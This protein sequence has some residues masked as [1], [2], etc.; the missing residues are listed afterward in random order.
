MFLRAMCYPFIVVCACWAPMAWGAVDRA[1]LERA[2]AL[3]KSGEFEQVYQLLEPQEVAGAGDLVF[4]YM[5]AS[6]ALATNRPSK[7]TFIYERILAVDPSYIGVRADMGRAY[8]AL[9]DFGRAKI[10]FET[11]LT[12]TNL[13][14]DL[15]STVEQYVKA[16]EQRAQ[17]KRTVTT[18][19]IELGFGRDSNIGSATNLA[20]IDLPIGFV[21]A[22]APPMGKQTADN[23]STL[24]LGAEV[25]HQLS[26]PWGL[27]AGA[28]YRARGYSTFTDPNTQSL[29]ARGGFSYSGGAWLLRSGLSV[30]TYEQNGKK[31]RDTS[32][33]SVDWR[34]AI[35]T[36]SQVT[37][38]AAINRAVYV[39]P[40]QASQNNQSASLNVGWLTALG[41]G[42]TVFS[43]SGS[44]GFERADGDRDDG[45][46]RFYG[47][48]LLLQ[49]SFNDRLGG[50]VTAGATRSEYGGINTLYALQ[51]VENLYDL[52][53]GM[54]WS[55]GKGVSV[56]PQVSYIK[57][58]SNA[59]LYSYEK[60]DGS[61]NLR[62]DL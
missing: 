54:T 15:R 40:E 31:I 17:A 34:S 37:V 1:L 11:V 24:G 18:A 55:I 50:Y 33:L 38:G 26:D 52:T 51:R 21:Y 36:S 9:G 28:D 8:F 7:A 61:L 13:P 45:D 44:S 46:K 30:G 42:T 12:F 43:V 59:Q 5:L 4:D 53:F 49:T 39:Q 14:L 48:R 3:T 25:N 27:Y 29:D 62:V 57:N 60:L 6:A 32:G 47:P 19:Y 23:Y 10:E 56:R 20:E 35:T 41:D 16:A 58:D 2:D 22:P